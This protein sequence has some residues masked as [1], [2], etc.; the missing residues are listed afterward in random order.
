M[1]TANAYLSL[2]EA[3]ENFTAENIPFVVETEDYSDQTLTPVGEYLSQSRSITKV[4]PKPDGSVVFELSL[5]G[6][7]QTLD[8]S[9]V[10]YGGGKYP[11][12]T[13]LSTKLFAQNGRPGQ[14]SGAAQYLRE[15][16]IDPKNLK[17]KTD[18]IEGMEASLMVPMKV[19]VARTDR[20]EKQPDGSYTRRNLKT[21]DFLV[22]SSPEG[23]PIYAA[24][25][26][27]NGITVK[28]TEKIGSFRSF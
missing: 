17:T 4:T 9:G 22:G 24:T 18:F 15:A 7:V 12:R 28:G 3:K 8:G 6:G 10:T 23:T 1:T 2:A 11:F 20:G 21:K 16:G 27:L 19:F 13:W 25:I 5:T 14:T 26:D